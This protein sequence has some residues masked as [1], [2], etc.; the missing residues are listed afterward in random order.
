V[1][2]AIMPDPAQCAVQSGAA[3]SKF[4]GEVQQ[5]LRERPSPMHA[6]LLSKKRDQTALHGFSR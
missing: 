3:Q 6:V 5:P 1:H 2:G 4:E